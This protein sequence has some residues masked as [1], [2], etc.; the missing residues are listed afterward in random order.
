MPSP[1]PVSRPR[2]SRPAEWRSPTPTTWRRRRGPRHSSTPRSN[3]SG[4][5]DILINN[6]GIIRWAGMPDVDADHLAQH[7]AVHVGGSFNTTRAAWPHM[8]EQGYG[9][10]VMT[11]SSGIFGLVENLAYATREGGSHRADAQPHDRGR[12]ARHLG[13]RDR[14]RGDDTDGGSL[15]RRR[16]KELDRADE[17]TAAAMAPDLVAPLVAFLAHETCPVSGEIYTAGGGRFARVFIADDRGLRRNLT[18]TDH[19]G[20]GGELGNDQRRDGILR[21]ARPHDVVGHV[22]DSLVPGEIGGLDLVELADHLLGGAAQHDA[23]ALHHVDAVGDLERLA[24]VLLDEEHADAPLVCARR[25]PPSSRLATMIG[26]NPRDSS[27]ASS[28]FGWRPRARASD[29]ICCSPPEQ[30]PAR[31]SMIRSSAGKYSNAT[32]GGTVGQLQVVGDRHV[33]DHRPLLGHVAETVP[34]PGVHRR[35]GRLARGTGPRPPSASARPRG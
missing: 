8:V 6:A 16:P 12:A 29:S 25:G 11:T 32:A 3:S 20:G 2:S 15:R 19:R 14:A 17:S 5:S 28:T 24:N 33:H 1:H 35:P 10:I 34:A 13:E 21:P 4:A 18:G 9:R 7:H 30:S 31:R 22:P 23:A 26:A 27:S